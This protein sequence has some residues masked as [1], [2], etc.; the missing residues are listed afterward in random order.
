MGRLLLAVAAL[1][2]TAAV[3]LPVANAG[4]DRPGASTRAK[5]KVE[6]K[7]VGSWRLLSFVVRSAEG[8][9]YPFGD[10]AVGKLTY[11]EE[12]NMWALVAR[13]GV[14]KNL[15]DATWYTGTFDIDVKRRTVIHHVQYSNLPTWEKGDQPRLYKLKANRL[16]LSVPP[17]E[18]GGATGVLKWK[19][20]PAR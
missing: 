6:R 2:S 11:T 9:D 7:L 17:A 3:G 20:L 8:I 1:A 13:R 12:G 19:K 16:T 18:P 15:P 4:A 14:P 5:A 10:D